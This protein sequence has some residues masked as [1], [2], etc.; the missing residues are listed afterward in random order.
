[1]S[2]S[3]IL[4]MPM[5]EYGPQNFVWFRSPVMNRDDIQRVLQN[6]LDLMGPEDELCLALFPNKSRE[7]NMGQKRAPDY[8]LVLIE[9]PPGWRTENPFDFV[10]VEPW[11]RQPREEKNKKRLTMKCG[12]YSLG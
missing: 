2:A 11:T 6:I 10:K 5:W 3:S 12:M 7:P 8:N 9:R 1:M 4:I